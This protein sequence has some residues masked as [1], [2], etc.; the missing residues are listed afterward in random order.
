MI[1]APAAPA[2][3]EISR[4][5]VRRRLRDPTLVLVDVL[6]RPAFEEA[7]IPGSLS[8][9]LDE[10]AENAERVLPDR[11]ADIAVYCGGFT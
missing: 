11:S 1:P 7:R 5:E 6:P 3:G 10:L 2:I 4:E 8:L 9:P